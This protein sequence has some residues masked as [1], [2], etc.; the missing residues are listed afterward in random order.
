[1]LSK[2]GL[3]GPRTNLDCGSSRILARR[4]LNWSLGLPTIIIGVVWTPQMVFTNPIMT[5]HVNRTIDRPPMSL[6]VTGRYKSID[7]KNP[8]G[9]QKPSIVIA[10]IFNHKCGHFVRPNK[11][12][13]KYLEFK[14]DVDIDVHVKI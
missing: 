1:M 10:K 12:A 6:M 11:V 8:E 3:I 14:K 13:L 2:V 7:A 4:N 9:Y 5:T